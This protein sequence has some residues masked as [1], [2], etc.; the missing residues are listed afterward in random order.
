MLVRAFLKF[1]PHANHRM[2]CVSMQVWLRYFLVKLPSF[3]IIV[4]FGTVGLVAA[5][6]KLAYQFYKWLPSASR[7]Y[8]AQLNWEFN[9]YW[10]DRADFFP[11]Q[12]A[13]FYFLLILTRLD[14]YLPVFDCEGQAA[15][16]QY[17]HDRRFVSGMVGFRNRYVNPKAW[18][19][20]FLRR[21]L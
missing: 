8:Y 14:K 11:S 6:R 21:F 13:R 20:L 10:R 5:I 16:A 19:V 3:P 9:R 18:P 2:E 15:K 1:T 12:L 17:H 7:I 4:M